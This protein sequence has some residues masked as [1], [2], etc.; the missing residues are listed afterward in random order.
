[1]TLATDP[2]RKVLVIPRRRAKPARA[3]IAIAS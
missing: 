2:E 3:A 1:L